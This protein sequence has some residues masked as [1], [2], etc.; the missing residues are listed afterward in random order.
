MSSAPLALTIPLAAVLL[1]PA[2][3]A[4]VAAR[5]GWAGTLRRPGRLGVHTVAAMS[6]DRA[7]SLANKVAAPVAGGAAVIGTVAA[8]IV[9]ALPLAVPA[10]LV[11]FGL[12]LVGL[13]ALLYAAAAMGE[14]A[15]RQVPPPA[16]KPGTGSGGS[17]S[18]GGCGCGEGGC[19]GAAVEPFAAIARP[20][21]VASEPAGAEFGPAA[22]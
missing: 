7:F 11:V 22:I 4:G 9:I 14:R 17:P 21:E 10:A 19:R 3:A 12:G 15:A 5:G 1:L 13:F 2:L 18:C 20:A 8:V 6:S 16:R